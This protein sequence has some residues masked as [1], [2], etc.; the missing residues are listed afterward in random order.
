[1]V[2]GLKHCNV[3]CS[4]EAFSQSDD[5]EKMFNTNAIA[6][7]VI[8]IAKIPLKL[9]N[10]MNVKIFQNYRAFLTQLSI[11]LNHIV[12]ALLEIDNRLH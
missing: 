7:S 8:G 6:T 3:F 1:M 2:T 12:L 10:K 5:D 4:V 9:G 11:V